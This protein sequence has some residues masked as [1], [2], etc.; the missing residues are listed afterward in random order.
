VVIF[1]ILICCT[2]NDKATL[3]HTHGGIRAYIDHDALLTKL[4]SKTLAN[5]N[6]A[7]PR[8]G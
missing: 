5:S 7:V 6:L 1:L 8:L 3:G 2:K 4:P